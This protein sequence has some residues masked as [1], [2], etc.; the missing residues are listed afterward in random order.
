MRLLFEP[1]GRKPPTEEKV[2][3][4]GTGRP[5]TLGE[6]KSLARRPSRDV[7]ERV[8]ADPHPDVIRNVLQN[9]KLTEADVV[10]VVSKRP[11]YEKVLEQIY[12]HPK[13]KVRYPV[14][15]AL[16]RN[17]YPPPAISLKLVP[18]LMRQDLQEMLD[19]RHL[20]PSVLLAVSR[21]LT[22]DIDE[23]ETGGETPVH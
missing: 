21:V 9:P 15:L 14:R 7:V 1:T 3:D 12:H 10:R 20:H 16:A 8:V 19:D 18:Q 6:R 4:Y 17:P 22:G 5:L 23:G 13:W 2:P 11:N